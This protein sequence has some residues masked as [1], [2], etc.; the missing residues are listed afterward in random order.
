MAK[1]EIAGK[2]NKITHSQNQWS[3]KKEVQHKKLSIADE[4]CEGNVGTCG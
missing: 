4:T 3:N 1:Q 2:Q